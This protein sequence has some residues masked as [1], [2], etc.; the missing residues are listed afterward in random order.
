MN[1]LTFLLRKDQCQIDHKIHNGKVL[2]VYVQTERRI[3]NVPI[4][5]HV[6]RRL[7]SK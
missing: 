3:I 6:R 7:E 2:L 4:Y 1:T 5:G